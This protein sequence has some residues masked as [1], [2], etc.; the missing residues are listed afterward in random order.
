MTELY[1]WA[2][3]IN[4]DKLHHVG[5][6]YSSRYNKPYR[7]KNGEFTNGYLDWMLQQNSNAFYEVLKKEFEILCD[8]DCR[9]FFIRRKRT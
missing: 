8:N 2:N 9:G 7:K 6:Y 1:M 3:E 4:D 5:E